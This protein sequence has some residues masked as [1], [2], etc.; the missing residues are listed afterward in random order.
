MLPFTSTRFLYSYYF[1]HVPIGTL[2]PVGKDETE[3]TDKLQ[4]I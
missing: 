3:A 2:S 4:D 1:A